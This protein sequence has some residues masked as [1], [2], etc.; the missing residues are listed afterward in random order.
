M[1]HQHHFLSRLDRVDM[2]QVELALGLYRDHELVRF[3]LGRLTLPEG[4]ER[5]AISLRSVK[6]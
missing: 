2:P 4:A 1:G 5:V 6:R 3:L